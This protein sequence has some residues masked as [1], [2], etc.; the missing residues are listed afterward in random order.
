MSSHYRG[1]RAMVTDAEIGPPT[2]AARSPV[3]PIDFEIDV[4]QGEPLGAQ[5]LERLL[6]LVH[7]VH[8]AFLPWS[9]QYVPDAA[10]PR[11]GPS[12]QN[13]VWCYVTP[14]SCY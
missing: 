11:P 6:L 3:H 7:D 9:F 5:P 8:L 13:L 1:A 10:V 4:V 2:L 14:R 12:V